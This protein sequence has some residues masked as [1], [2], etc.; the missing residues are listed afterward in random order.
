MKK[1]ERPEDETAPVRLEDLAEQAGV[2]I[3]TVSRALNGS[4]LVNEST[5]Q[6]IQALAERH[7]Y[8][9]RK[10]TPAA[11]RT[12]TRTIALLIPPPLG[13]QGRMSEPFYLDLIGGIGDA[14]KERGCDIL[15]SHL[16]PDSSDTL[17]LAIKA[18][19]AADGMVFLGQSV[20]H[21]AFNALAR[22]G[23]RFVVWGAKLPGQSYCSVGSDNP[24]GGYRA[25]SH[26]IRLNRR[27]IAFVG[28]VEAPEVMQ[29]Y[30]GYR[31]ALADAGLDFEPG[32]LR[33]AA[34][35]P[36]AAG[37]SMDSLIDGQAPVDAVFAA[38]DLIAIGAI[39]ALNRRGIR[40]PED[41]AVVG[42][43][44]IQVAAYAHPALTTV[45]Q[46]VEKAGRLIVGRILRLLNGEKVTSERLPTELVVRESCGA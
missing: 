42:Y 16:S 19:A 30:D 25:T 37:E 17:A 35:Y 41:V 22:D 31:Q 23:G 8:V 46:D 27:C 13:R 11:E 28:D 3:A 18:V 29:R 4:D 9:L 43:D 10:R 21:E 26:L 24:R 34:F 2:S 20:L 14:A 38:S 12:R 36:E 40:V 33:R 1:R 15:I 6:R 32:L 5:K 44:D 39:R 7:N 45:R